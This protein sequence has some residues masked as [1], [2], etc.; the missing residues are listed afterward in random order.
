[1]ATDRCITNFTVPSINPPKPARL[2]L[3]TAGLGYRQL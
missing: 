1:M 3:A 2:T